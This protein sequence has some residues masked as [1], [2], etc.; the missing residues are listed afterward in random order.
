VEDAD[1]VIGGSAWS[2]RAVLMEVRKARILGSSA[3][4]LPGMLGHLAFLS[5][6]FENIERSVSNCFHKFGPSPA[7]KPGCPSDAVDYYGLG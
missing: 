4:Y 7:S 3:A 5:A 6:L 1:R 2:L